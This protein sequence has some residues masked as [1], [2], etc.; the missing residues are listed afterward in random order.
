MHPS[1]KAK[2]RLRNITSSLPRNINDTWSDRDAFDTGRKLARQDDW[3]LLSALMM[4]ADEGR[5][6]TR[7]GTPLCEALA[8]GARADAIMVA[9]SAA[10]RG[11]C[12]DAA[13]CLQQLEDVYSEDNLDPACGFVLAMAH[14]DTARAFA[15]PTDDAVSPE[16]KKHFKRA[17]EIFQ[18]FGNQKDSSLLIAL[19]RCALIDAR[20]NHCKDLAPAYDALIAADPQNPRHLRHYGRSLVTRGIAPEDI[21]A[22]MAD[23]Y[24]L[25]AYIWIYVGAL[26]QDAMIVSSLNVQKFV[27][28]VRKVLSGR[29]SQVTANRLAA[30]CAKAARTMPEN[31]RAQTVLSECAEWVSD[32][33]IRQVQPDIWHGIIGTEQPKHPNTAV[34][35]P[36]AQKGVLARLAQAWLSNR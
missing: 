1:A 15:T 18:C 22:D 25:Q 33:H 16:S 8:K 24:D 13:A 29:T 28:G 19:L 7:E 21:A 14:L 36:P 23:L 5:N 30:A 10:R 31:S 3:D 12:D 32:N 35:T 11:E 2:S 20:P 4:D 34:P 9:Q 27:I 26:A 17:E 6:A